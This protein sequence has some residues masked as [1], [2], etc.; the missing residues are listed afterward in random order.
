MYKPKL[1]ISVWLIDKE[2]SGFVPG[3]NIASSLNAKIYLSI[4]RFL[5]SNRNM[6]KNSFSKGE[7][8]QHAIDFVPTAIL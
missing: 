1:T 8:I 7:T 2:I 6:T 5:T 4:L 3:I